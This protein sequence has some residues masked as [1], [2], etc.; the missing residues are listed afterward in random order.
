[1]ED[2]WKKIKNLINIIKDLYKTNTKNFVY[3]F[4]IIFSDYKKV[5]VFFIILP[6][7]YYLI[8]IQIFFCIVFTI[9]YII[10]FLNVYSIK[11]KDIIECKE[12][13]LNP[14]YIYR[15]STYNLIIAIPKAKAFL[16]VYNIIENIFIKNKN[17]I[18]FYITI[19]SILIV[20]LIYKISFLFIFGVSYISIIICSET[21]IKFFNTI[22]LNYDTKKA[23][24]QTVLIN[25]FILS[26]DSIANADEK[27]IIIEKNNIIFNSEI[28]MKIFLNKVKKSE[29]FDE[30]V[31]S[32]IRTV[33]AYVNNHY[34]YIQ[35]S[36]KYKDKNIANNFTSKNYIKVWSLEGEKKIPLKTGYK[37]NIMGDDKNNYLTPN[38]ELDLKN[39]F[40]SEINEN[41]SIK[42]NNFKKAAE[43]H[44]LLSKDEQILNSNKDKFTYDKNALTITEYSKKYEL[45]IYENIKKINEFENLN[46]DYFNSNEGKIEYEI[47]K[48]ISKKEK[49]DFNKLYDVND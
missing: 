16:L 29:L 44:M 27:K 43:N 13:E 18:F 35:H 11:S 7:V 8:K 40:I 41:K 47:A 23:L 12:L 28:F 38:Y 17:D 49:I 25:C 36:I 24:I 2:K 39:F 14:T 31:N 46:K 20:N 22:N 5:I 4:I 37:P 42:L 33:S 19:L 1:M 26:S 21:V 48:K 6:I 9:Y 34:T 45:P 15:Y 30:A 3:N 10:C 32:T